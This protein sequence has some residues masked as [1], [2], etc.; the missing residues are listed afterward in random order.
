MVPTR[1]LGDQLF[2]EEVLAARAMTPEQRV[3]A[4]AELFELACRIARDGI[5]HQYPDATDEEV[6]QRLAERLELQRRLEE[7]P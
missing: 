6:A 4:G 2:R 5:R 3:R 1:E 7:S